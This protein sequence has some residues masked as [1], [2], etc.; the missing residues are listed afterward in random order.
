MSESE[1][2]EI[3]EPLEGVAPIQV[4]VHRVSSPS[5]FNLPRALRAIVSPSD[6]SIKIEFRYIED[7]ATKQRMLGENVTAWIGKTSK[8]IRGI[9][10]R[11]KPR[12]A[13]DS[14]N[15]DSAIEQLISTLSPGED[16]A[17]G[18]YRI[19]GRVVKAKLAEIET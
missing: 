11:S 4:S 16:Q 1:W 8:R 19:V 9:Q 3:K 14:Q 2:Q 5:P 7:E 18:N 13:S 10:I 6:Q 12:S 15:L 17:E